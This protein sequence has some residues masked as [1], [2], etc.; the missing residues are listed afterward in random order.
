MTYPRTF[1]IGETLWTP[2]S[3]KNWN[4]FVTR[5]EDHFDRFDKARLNY[6]PSMYDPIIRV[7]KN[8]DG[9]LVVELDT[10]VQG[11]D[12]YYTLDNT[13]P[14][15]Y[16]PKYKEAVALPPDV[17]Q[18]RVMTYRGNKPVGRLISLKTEDL[19]KRVRK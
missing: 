13:F 8:T 15:Q 12:V 19:E 1:A 6:A 4:S 11:L 7:K 16:S 2:K 3:K 10:E 14:N 5:V 17:D 18:V 9:R